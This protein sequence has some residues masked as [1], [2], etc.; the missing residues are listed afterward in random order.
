MGL[1]FA[2]YYIQK[3]G[4]KKFLKWID[5]ETTIKQINDG[6]RKQSGVYKTDMQGPMNKVVTG[7]DMFGDKVGPFIK[8]IQGVSDENVVDIW[9]ARGFNRKV[10]N[11]WSRNADGKIRKNKEGK[12]IA[13]GEPRNK[14]E[15]E[16]MSRYMRGSKNVGK[17]V[18][19]R[20]V[21]GILNKVYT[22]R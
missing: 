19:A 8:N 15:L 3:N 17:S 20:A 10:G 7:A 9:N 5:T 2:D 16:I 6:V 12:L 13:A 14:Q 22:H 18:R 11:V 1:E 21:Y 4:L